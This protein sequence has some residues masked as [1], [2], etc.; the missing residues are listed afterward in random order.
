MQNNNISIEEFWKREE[1]PIA[2]SPI[3]TTTITLERLQQ[4]GYESMRGYYEKVNP[5]L[6]EPLYLPAG[7]QVRG[8]YV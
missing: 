8:P 5:Q 2:Q 1:M 4:R 3:L 6:N 7:R